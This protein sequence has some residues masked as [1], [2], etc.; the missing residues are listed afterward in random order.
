MVIY[1]D[2]S[3]TSNGK[4][5]AKGGYG[6]VVIDEDTGK[7]IAARSKR[8][9]GTTNNREELK[10]IL[11]AMLTYS[12]TNDDWGM[13]PVVY[14]DS[15][16]CVQ[17]FNEWMFGWARNGWVKSDKKTPENLDLIQ[18]YF[19]WYRKGHRIDLRK[20]KGHAG[21]KWNELADQLATGKIT[22]E[23]VMKIYG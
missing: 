22:P 17:T 9:E 20:V 16:Y 1:T 14:S 11:Y 5:N 19:D 21:D 7:V 23:E 8:A 18:A 13:P 3:C 2:G 12:I 15:N 10:A 4:A 6:V